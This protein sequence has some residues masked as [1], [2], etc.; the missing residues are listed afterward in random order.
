MGI[1]AFF[2]HN[3]KQPSSRSTFRSRDA[4]ASGSCH[5]PPRTRGGRSADRRPGAAAPGWPAAS[6]KKTHR[7]C[8]T[9]RAGA[10]ARRPAS[11]KA[12]GT[13]ASRRSTVAILGRGPRFHHGHFLP[14]RA[15]SSSQP[16]RSAWRAGSPASRGGR[17]RAASRGTPLPAPPSGSSPETPLDERGCA[18]CSAIPYRSK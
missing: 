1:A 11:L 10:L 3:V 7:S 14:I 13:R 4:F 15:A 18:I 16:G 9:R 2:L 17:L 5:C 12:G 8:V 6:H